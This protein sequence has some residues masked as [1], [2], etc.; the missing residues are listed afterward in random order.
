MVGTTLVAQIGF[1]G[2][3]IAALGTYSYKK[4][5]K[6][7]YKL[8]P[9]ITQTK[10]LELL[11]LFGS[12]LFVTSALYLIAD[13]SQINEYILAV[14]ISIATVLI[15]AVIHG[16]IKSLEK[17]VVIECYE[18]EDELEDSDES[19]FISDENASDINSRIS[20]AKSHSEKDVVDDETQNREET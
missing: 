5:I 2:A 1:F 3:I 7:Y 11:I 8:Y 17:K 10:A 4:K 20:D 9:H 14:G 16:I 18:E 6:Q 15:V 19:D 13:L 12:L